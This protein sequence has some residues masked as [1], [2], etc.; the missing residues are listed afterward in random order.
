MTEG[1][2][3]AWQHRKAE[4]NQTGWKKTTIERAREK[5]ECK[6]TLYGTQPA[7]VITQEKKNKCKNAKNELSSYFHHLY[8][9]PLALSLQLW[10]RGSHSCSYSSRYSRLKWPRS[11]NFKYAIICINTPY[12]IIAALACLYW[13][14]RALPWVTNIHTY[15]LKYTTNTSIPYRFDG[16]S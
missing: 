5:K 1:W 11:Q 12:I 4:P 16:A 8:F 15:V 3:H 9:L 6:F 10:Q 7:L 2:T 13:E 14:A